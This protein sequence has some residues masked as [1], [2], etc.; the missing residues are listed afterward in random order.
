VWQSPSPPRFRRS[1]TCGK[2]QHLD[3]QGGVAVLIN[4]AL[5]VALFVFDWPDFDF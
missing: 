3:D 5:L 1:R 4:S 2:W